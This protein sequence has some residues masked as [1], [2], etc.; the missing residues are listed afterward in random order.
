MK[1]KLLFLGFCM[2]FCGLLVPSTKVS[3]E[4]LV[5]YTGHIT[6]PEFSGVLEEMIDNL[7]QTMA[8]SYTIDWSIPK[9]ERYTTAYF[10]KE[11]GTSVGVVMNLSG[12][13]WVG[14][15]DMDGKARYVA[16][17]TRLAHSFKITKTNYYSFFVYNKSG[18]KITAKGNYTK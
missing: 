10:K 3:A 7:Y 11:E 13:G 12:Y 1:G 8:T 9:N 6:D 18:A 17:T 16:G 15:I 4:E 5:E 2:I 14:I